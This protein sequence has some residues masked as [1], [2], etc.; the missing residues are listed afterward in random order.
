MASQVKVTEQKQLI[1]EL[2]KERELARATQ[3]AGQKAA[4]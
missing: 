4:N 1:D 3:S 2:R